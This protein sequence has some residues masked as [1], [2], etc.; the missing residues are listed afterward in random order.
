MKKVGRLF[1]EKLVDQLKDGVQENKNVF[2]LS[3]S[4]VVGLQMSELRKD[5]NK[6]GAQ[7]CVSRNSIARIALKDLENPDL[8]DKVSGQTAFVWSNEDSAEV[9]KIL[10]KFAKDSEVISLQGGLLE[11]TVLAE[12]DVK[13][14]ADLP[15]R[16]VLLST[17]LGTIQAP[18]T[19]LAGALNA[20][21]RDLLSI[22]KQLSEKTGGE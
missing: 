11:G 18:M 20:K 13:K 6:V 5:L 7:V 9:S 16:S 17:L 8:A 10:V 2:V 12:A 14:L 21:S 1:R 4:Q 15:P 3:Y 22:L 19:R